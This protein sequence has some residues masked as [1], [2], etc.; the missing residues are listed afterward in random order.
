MVIASILGPLTRIAAPESFVKRA[1]NSR[2]ETRQSH[3]RIRAKRNRRDTEHPE[4]KGPWVLQDQPLRLLPLRCSRSGE[5][6]LAV[7]LLP[8]IEAPPGIADLGVEV[9]EAQ[10]RIPGQRF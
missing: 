8:S 10:L 2:P 1:C 9:L 4:T 6:F 7:K 3:S 5:K